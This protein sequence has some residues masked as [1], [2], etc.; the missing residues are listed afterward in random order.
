MQQRQQKS[1][2]RPRMEQ[3][4][5]WWINS[6]PV[7]VI[8]VVMKI[9]FFRR[10]RR[11]AHTPHFPLFTLLLGSAAALLWLFSSSGGVR[12]CICAI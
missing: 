4:E 3:I 11:A 9:D 2:S 12:I 1:S 6:G 7:I 8:V 5:G 10:A